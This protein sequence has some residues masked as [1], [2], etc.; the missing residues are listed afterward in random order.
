MGENNSGD[1]VIS[2]SAEINRNLSPAGITGNL[3]AQ[4][5]ASGKT[6][7]ATHSRY[8]EFNTPNSRLWSYFG[9]YFKDEIQQAYEYLRNSGKRVYTT[10][11]IVAYVESLTS[12]IIGESFYNKDAGSKYLTQTYYKTEG[13]VTSIVDNMLTKLQ[14]N[15]ACR[16]RQISED[17]FRFLDTFFSNTSGQTANTSIS[18]RSDAAKTGVYT[19]QVGI[20]V[21]SPCYIKVAVGTDVTL[22]TYIDLNSRYVYNDVEYEGILLTLPLQATNK[23]ITIIGAGNIKSINH[24]ENLLITNFNCANATKL[25]SIVI[26]NSPALASLSLGSN[27]Y[28]RTL[29]LNN[30]K[31]L[32]GSLNLSNCANLIEVD[33]ANTSVTS[34]SLPANG[35]LE[36]FNASNSKLTSLSFDGLVFL[37][38]IDISGCTDIVSYSISNCPKISTVDVSG[39]T[40]LAQL[41]VNACS[42]VERLELANTKLANL[43]ITACDSLTAINLSGCSGTVMNNLNLSTIYNLED[44]NIA[45]ATPA[46][47]IKLYLPKYKQEYSQLSAEAINDLISLGTD[48][49][50]RTLKNFDARNSYLRNISYGITQLEDGTCDF[51]QLTGLESLSLLNCL[52]IL[53]VTNIHYAGNLY[54][55]LEGCYRLITITGSLEATSTNASNLFYKCSDLTNLAA[56]DLTLSLNLVTDFAY[57]LAG[58]INLSAADIKYVLDH[59]PN[60]TN[61][62]TFCSMAYRES[63]LTYPDIKA[64]VLPANLFTTNTK[65]T[66]L[67]TAFYGTKFTSIPSG[68]FTPFRTTLISANHAFYYCPLLVTVPA[69]LLTTC[70]A[71]T[72]TFSMFAGCDKLETYFGT[73]YSIFASNSKVT[74]IDKMFYNCSKLK[75]STSNTTGNPSNGLKTFFTNLPALQYG[76]L[77]FA[78]TSFITGLPEALFESNVALKDLTMLFLN[79]ATITNLP[80]ALFK[81]NLANTATTHPALQYLNG[82]FC[83]C[84]AMTGFAYTHLFNGAENVLEIGHKILNIDS[85][86]VY[87]AGMFANT[88]IDGYSYNFLRRLTKLV[89]AS[90][91]F[92]KGTISGNIFTPTTVGNNNDALINV[93]DENKAYVG[94][95]NGIFNGLNVL[96]D[97]RYVF[98]GNTSLTDIITIENGEAVSVT[99]P[100]LFADCKATLRS[101][102]GLFAQCTNL[103]ITIPISLFQNA[104]ALRTTRSAFAGCESLTGGLSNT[105]FTG[106]S[107]LQR[108][109]YMFYGCKGIGE[110]SNPTTVAIPSN[111]FDSCRAS[112]ITTAHMFDGCEKLTGILQTGDVT[113]TTDPEGTIIYTISRYG[114]LSECVALNS[115]EGMFRGCK[116]LHGAIPEDLFFTSSIL[117]R[118]NNLTNIAYMFDG[119][120]K[121][122]LSNSAYTAIDPRNKQEIY[123][124][125]LSSGDSGYLV[126]GN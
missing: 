58:N 24:M 109:D 89:S 116:E 36:T 94:V 75:A 117:L 21:Y 28:L 32:A 96:R 49:Y 79:C 7:D 68:F 98:A 92:F 52:R 66:N 48:V 11:Y 72:T 5:D 15:R 63:G 46:N 60:V 18:L 61:L 55:L 112:L 106:C 59:L 70:T 122:G 121:L 56:G 6:L 105:L 17:R 13:G 34:V 100:T 93:Y 9:T 73:N 84:T 118:Y 69:N 110:N 38:T 4:A 67:S 16:Y 86:Y 65:V 2:A 101:C 102:E 39:Y 124:D 99:S 54:R 33:F 19:Q 64:I 104:T 27:T 35:A 81:S 57:G 77:A 20:S 40:G 85:G 43:S 114:L 23:D 44:L 91:L 87:C 111:I 14:G 113:K 8:I 125:A 22:M 50:W 78:N 30:S 10:E 25:T 123:G 26:A 45:A 120:Y 76:R 47:N 71:L 37:D 41:T 97:A 80:T 29:N 53:K 62:G 107:S 3:A 119:C 1:D 51:S 90:M 12:D 88:K 31:T 42:A 83:G 108:T 74:N 126:P 103:A 115:V 95:Y 82:L